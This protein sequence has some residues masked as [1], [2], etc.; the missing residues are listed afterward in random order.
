M[1]KENKEE[2]CVARFLNWYNKQH[3]RNYIYRRAT[4]YFPD[5]KGKLNWDFVAYE[6]DNLAKWIGNE[7]KELPRLKEIPI[8]LEFWQRLCSKLTKDLSGKGIKGQFEISVPPVL[9]LTGK[10]QK[11]LEAFSRV[12]IDKQSG[13]QVGETKDI[14]PDIASKFSNWPTGKSDVDEYDKWGEDRPRKLQI[15]KGSDS[16][17]EVR[18]VTSPLI[19]GDVVEAHKEAFN[20]VFKIENDAIRATKQLKLAKEKGARET[21]LLL[22]CNPFVEEGLIKNEAQNLDRHSIS[23][24]DYIYLVD[25]GNKDRVVKIYPS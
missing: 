1:D 16:G 13:W 23:D 11:F 24:I 7:V 17:C 18:V 20:E 4:D 21:I 15:K 14:G 19:A 22:A 9:D 6:D 2:I 8:Q 3:K 12:L 5:L 10:C 25:T